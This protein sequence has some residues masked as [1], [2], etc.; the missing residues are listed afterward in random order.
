MCRAGDAERMEEVRIVLAAFRD[1]TRAAVGKRSIACLKRALRNMGVISSD[2]VAPGTPALSGPDRD[3]FD[4]VF[5]DVRGLAAEHLPPT[6]I[7]TIPEAADA[8]GRRRA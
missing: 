7:S 3:R 8:G 5:E 6:W 4:E 2:A 1:R